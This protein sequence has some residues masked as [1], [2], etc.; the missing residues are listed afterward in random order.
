MFE[1][2]TALRTGLT[3]GLEAMT[4]SFGQMRRDVLDVDVLRGTTMVLLLRAARG[5]LAASW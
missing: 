3:I 4:A 2:V 1:P 5:R